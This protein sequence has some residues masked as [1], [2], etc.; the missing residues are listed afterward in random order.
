MNVAFYAVGVPLPQ[1]S[2]SAR[3]VKGRAIVTEGFGE[4]PRNRRRWRDAVAEAARKW[5]GENGHPAPVD[6]PVRLRLTFYLP[7]P[8]SAPRRVTQPAKKPDL[9]KLIRS[10]EDSL[11]GIIYADDARVVA[12][13]ASKE[14][15]LERTPGVMVEVAWSSW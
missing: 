1:G 2:K 5:A 13:E 12:I 14:F 7:R 11:S 3:V 9:S 8:A 15:A 4:G 6:L 10:V